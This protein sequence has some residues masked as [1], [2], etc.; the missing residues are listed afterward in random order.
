[1]LVAEGTVAV[2]PPVE[3]EVSPV[4]TRKDPRIPEFDPNTGAKLR[5]MMGFGGEHSR[6]GGTFAFMKRP[7]VCILAV[8]KNID[9]TKPFPTRAGMSLAWYPGLNIQG[10]WVTVY[11]HQL[12]ELEEAHKRQ[13]N[14]TWE[15]VQS[16]IALG[17]I[18]APE[19]FPTSLL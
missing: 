13:F 9:A 15:K 19:D 8:K 6:M 18:P 10:C 11:N 2:L 4:A 3:P 17:R 14:G 5:L 12:C 7:K 1:M 16:M